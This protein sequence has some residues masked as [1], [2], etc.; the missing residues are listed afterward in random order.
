MCLSAHGGGR[1]QAMAAPAV[2]RERHDAAHSVGFFHAPS[3]PR[4]GLFSPVVRNGPN[5]LLT[6]LT[7][8][9]FLG[10]TPPPRARHALS[11]PGEEERP[12]SEEIDI[13]R[14]A[15]KFAVPGTTD[16]MGT[17]IEGR[18]PIAHLVSGRHADDPWRLD[19]IR[20]AGLE[21]SRPWV[22]SLVC[23]TTSRGGPRQYGASMRS[24]IASRRPGPQASGHE[25]RR[26]WRTLRNRSGRPCCAGCWCWSWKCATVRASSRPGGNTRRGFRD[27]L[28]SS[29][30][31]SRRS[32]SLTT[33]G[34]LE[35][36]LGPLP[37]STHRRQGSLRTDPWAY[38]IS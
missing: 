7:I 33:G 23:F 14:R 22:R 27:T 15:R 32:R 17:C 4:P 31:C 21:A 20:K 35:Q 6:P 5:W 8:F 11:L 37:R 1:T 18:D 38:T 19:R 29:R 24:A 30:R 28:H 9:L 13:L 12:T 36:G 26:S 10:T 34:H 25:S 2:R 3:H 16:R